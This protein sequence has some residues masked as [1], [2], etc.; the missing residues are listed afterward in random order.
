MR[1]YAIDESGK[2]VFPVEQGAVG[3]GA[4]SDDSF[5]YIQGEPLF[6]SPQG[7]VAVRGTDVDNQRLIQDVSSLINS[8]L[9]GEDL[10]QAI[11]VEYRNRYYLFVNGKV[12]V[13]DARM[14]YRDTLNNVQYE[15]YDWNNINATCAKVYKDYLLFGFG[16]M[17]FRFKAEGDDNIFVDEDYNGTETQIQSYWTTPN[18]YFGSITNRK[19][20]DNLYLMFSARKNISVN[21]KCVVDDEQEIDLGTY[22]RYSGFD[23]RYIDF[24][25]I[26]FI[27]SPTVSEKI[28]A[29][30]RNFDNIKFTISNVNGVVNTGIG[31]EIIQA[32]YRFLAK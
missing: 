10:S 28:N 15:W 25:K 21:I 30:I 12:Y 32:I 4:I 23:F 29:C 8:K 3:I 22:E 27:V 17:V 11:G 20:L 16:G 14:R 6:V 7:V 19:C 18:L 31:L 26:S 5:A 24:R 13:C 1:N 2:P 9:I